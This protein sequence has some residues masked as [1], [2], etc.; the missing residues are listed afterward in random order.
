VIDYLYIPIILFCMVGQ[1]FLAGIETGVISIHRMRLRHFVRKGSTG[2]RLLQE[3][4]DDTDRL[5]GTTLVG[6]NI[7]VVVISVVSASLA[8]K[9]VGQWGEAFSTVL[10]SGLVLVFCEYLPKAWFH[11]RPL[12][13]CRRFTGL[14]RFCEIVLMPLSKAVVGVT[15]WLIP[16]DKK[17]FSKPVPFVTREDLKILAREGEKDGVLSERERTMIHRVFDLSGKPARQIMIPRSD[18]VM[19]Y[20]ETTISEFYDVARE[21]DL[22]RLPVYDRDTKKFTGV[23]NVFHVI[24][25]RPD[26]LNSPV[27]ALVRPLL[28]IPEDMPADD[29]IP[30]MRRSR[31]PLA[32]VVDKDEEVTGLITT[33]DVLEEIVGKL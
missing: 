15:R 19:V 27:S 25:S 33:E 2:A 20:N 17:T 1:A 11:S 3:Y 21:H 4:L 5:F 31:Q 12:E 30:R 29:I 28:L 22:T 24:S 13:R 18:I 7:C 26:D 6:T 16:S 32:L 8:V 14:L 9:V 10:V 23:V